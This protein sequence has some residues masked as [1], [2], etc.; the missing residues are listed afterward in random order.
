LERL[1]LSEA[2][3]TLRLSPRSLQR[4]ISGGALPTV[5]IGRRTLIDVED[6]RRLVGRSASLGPR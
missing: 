3:E 2:A 5:R 1:T 6:L 4:L